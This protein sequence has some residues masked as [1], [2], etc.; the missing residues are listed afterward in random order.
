MHDKALSPD[1]G[2]E[3]EAGDFTGELHSKLL[4]RGSAPAPL[5]ARPTLAPWITTCDYTC[6]GTYLQ[7]RT[8]ISISVAQKNFNHVQISHRNP[9]WQT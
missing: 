7:T 3:Q 2:Q 4:A 1:E 6:V 8:P 5:A 9:S